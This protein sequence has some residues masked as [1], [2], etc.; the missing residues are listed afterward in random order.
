MVSA[1]G[2]TPKRIISRVR[3][4]TFDLFLSWLLDRT[5]GQLPRGFVVTLPKITS[6]AQVSALADACDEIERARGLSHGALAVEL[7]VETTQSIFSAE[8]GIALPQL[9]AAGRGRVTGA[10]FGTYDYTAALSITA[11]HQQMTHPAC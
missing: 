2:R 1:A 7:M 3:L 8:G 10:H 11:A 9:V 6:P 5:N 4:R